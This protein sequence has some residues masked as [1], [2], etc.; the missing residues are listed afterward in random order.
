MLKEAIDRSDEMNAQKDEAKQGQLSVV[1][2]T[3]EH[4]TTTGAIDRILFKSDD[5]RYVVATLKQESG[6]TIVIC[7]TR[8]LRS[9]AHGRS[10]PSM[11][12]GFE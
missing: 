4:L 5:E 1:E 2:P 9:R 11:A 3:S 7:G 6:E 10:T 12:S 8:R